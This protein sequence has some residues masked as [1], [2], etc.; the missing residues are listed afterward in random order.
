MKSIYVLLLATGSL[1]LL[2]LQTVKA[3]GMSA[4][5]A[6]K[7]ALIN[8]VKKD[9]DAGVVFKDDREL[10]AD[11]ISQETKVILGALEIGTSRF[12]YHAIDGFADGENKLVDA[13][14]DK[15]KASVEKRGGIDPVY[16]KKAE[17]EDEWAGNAV[18][19]VWAEDIDETLALAKAADAK[20]KKFPG[21]SVWTSRAISK[22]ER[23]EWRA[24]F[25]E[26]E[27]K[28]RDRFNKQLD[29]LAALSKTK[30]PLII[31]SDKLF[32]T[33]SAT[34]AEMMLNQFGERDN[35]KVYKIGSPSPNE[36]AIQKEDNYINYRYKEAYMWAKVTNEDI[37]YCWLFY[38]EIRQDYMGKG[39]YGKSYAKYA[40]RSLTGCPQ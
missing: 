8:K 19:Q 36:W 23:N 7:I 34:E 5:A 27:L 15:L 14:L 13:A 3:Q 32:V 31:P 25:Q 4:A 29:E 37:P 30:I 10:Y 9:V 16:G 2:G 20:N 22:K 12:I 28:V 39:E 35:F 17:E 21:S 26:N 33:K 11:D 18:F 38:I 24:M 6:K 40:S 1:L